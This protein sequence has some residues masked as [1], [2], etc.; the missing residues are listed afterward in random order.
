MTKLTR[1]S[2]V[3]V[4]TGLLCTACG[5][6]DKNKAPRDPALDQKI[7]RLLTLILEVEQ[8]GAAADD[9]LALAANGLIAELG[10]EDSAASILATRLLDNAERWV[11]LLDS[12]ARVATGAAAITPSSP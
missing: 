12:L 5:A 10:G 4:M 8:S 1:H 3:I 2:I 11:P 7:E 6:S 9:S